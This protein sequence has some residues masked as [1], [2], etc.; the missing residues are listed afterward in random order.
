[1]MEIAITLPD[2]SVALQLALSLGHFLW[3]GVL[4]SLLAFVAG[5]VQRSRSQ[6]QYAVHVVALVL[7][8]ACFPLN[9]FW[10]TSSIKEN[11][12]PQAAADNA[13]GAAPVSHGQ[14]PFVPETH[15]EL[16]VSQDVPRRP[17]STVPGVEP[18]GRRSAQEVAPLTMATAPPSSAAPVTGIDNGQSDAIRV[19]APAGLL[20][21]VSTRL[22]G[23]APILVQ[24][25]LAGVTVLLLRLVLAASCGCA[26]RRNASPVADSI[27]DTTRHL[28]HRIGIQ[29]E[30]FVGC[31]ESIA[32]PVAIGLFRP[33]ILIPSAILTGLT[34]DQ[35]Q[36]V[37]LHELSH[38]R[39]R[40][41]L[42]VILQRLVE[43][44]LFFH[45]A[46]WI[47]SRQISI[48]REHCCDADVVKWGAG[49][50]E[51]AGCLLQIAEIQSARSSACAVALA[52]DGHRPSQLRS[53]VSRIL[54]MPDPEHGRITVSGILAVV[55][56]LGS[57]LWSLP[58]EAAVAETDA[59]ATAISRD[60]RGDDGTTDPSAPTPEMVSLRP[61]LRDASG[62]SVPLTTGD[63]ERASIGFAEAVS[64][65]IKWQDGALRLKPG[66]QLLAY[67]PA[68]KGEAMLVELTVPPGD[69][70][71]AISLRKR[72]AWSSRDQVALSVD[73][74]VYKREFGNSIRLTFQNS[75]E[76]DFTFLRPDIQLVTNRW[77]IIPTEA[78]QLDGFTLTRDRG[79]Y[80]HGFSWSNAV[81]HGIWI[82]RNHEVIT[83]SLPA[84]EPG[85]IWLG[86]QIGPVLLPNQLQ[87]ESPDVVIARD[88]RYRRDGKVSV[89]LDKPEFVLGENVLLH[90]SVTN[91]GEEPLRIDVGGDYRGSPRSLRF[92]VHAYDK[93]GRRLADP[94]PN[95]W[96]HGG[97][98]TQPEIQ[99]GENYTLS[100]PLLDYVQIDKP[101]TYRVR[102]FH[103]LGWN[104]SFGIPL[105]EN[106]VMP[107][108]DTVAPIVET[109]LRIREP[110]RED[111]QA[112]VA[113]AETPRPETAWGTRTP[114]FGEWSAMR[115]PVYLPFLLKAADDHDEVLETIALIPTQEATEALLRLAENGSHRAASLLPR[116]LP[117]PNFKKRK[118]WNDAWSLREQLVQKSWRSEFAERTRQIAW[119][120][121]ESTETE[122]YEERKMDWMLGGSILFHIGRSEDYARFVTAASPIVESLGTIAA[123]QQQYPSPLTVI[124]NFV[125]TGDQLIRRGARPDTAPQTAFESMMFVTA[126]QAASE[127]RPRSWQA[128][129]R[130]LL[131]HSMPR[132]RSTCVA[133]LPVP[134]E[135][136]FVDP[137]I[138]L[139]S[140]SSPLVAATALNSVGAAKDSRF[141][142]A[143][144][145]TSRESLDKWVQ[146]AARH[147]AA[148][149]T[150]V[151]E[152]KPN[153]VSEPANKPAS[154]AD[155]EQRAS[156]N[157][158]RVQIAVKR[159]E[160]DRAAL[161]FQRGFVTELTV[162]KLELDLAN[163]ATT[164]AAE[165]AARA[166]ALPHKED[167]RLSRRQRT[168][169]RLELI[170][171]QAV[172][173]RAAL[174]RAKLLQEK[175]LINRLEVEK[176]EFE[177]QTLL[178]RKVAEERL[179]EVESQDKA[180]GE[181]SRKETLE[182]K[183]TGES[184]AGVPLLF[185]LDV[186]SRTDRPLEYWCGGPGL[187]PNA[188]MFVAT[189]TDEKGESRTIVLHNGQNLEGSGVTRKVERKTSFPAA[190]PPLAP[191]RY[192]VTVS[193]GQTA[194]LAGAY[195]EQWPEMKSKPVAIEIRDEPSSVQRVNDALLDL[196]AKSPFA[197]HVTHVY[198]ISP[199]VDEWLR[200]LLND[201]PREAF[202]VVGY[203]ARCRRLPKGGDAIVLQAAKKHSTSRR[204]DKNLLR[205]ISMIGRNIGSESTIDAVMAIAT[206]DV[207]RYARAAAVSD[208]AE[209]PGPLAEKRLEQLA[210][211]PQSPVYWPAI[212][213]L[214]ARRNRLA[215]T[216]LLKALETA[217]G[218]RR[219]Q[220]RKLLQNFPDDPK[221][222]EAVRKRPNTGDSEQGASRSQNEG[223]SGEPPNAADNSADQ[224]SPKR[225]REQLLSSSPWSKPLNGLRIR[226][227]TD[228]QTF[229]AGDRLPLYVQL[230]NASDRP[231]PFGKLHRQID[232]RVTAN[233]GEWLGV[234][235]A[236]HDISPWEGLSGDFQPG[237]LIQWT[238]WLERA[239]LNRTVP[240]G[241][242]VT[243]KVSVPTQFTQPGQLP[244]T[245]YSEP[246]RIRFDAVPKS[247]LTSSDF[248]TGWS[249]E[250][251]IIYR[252]AGG[253]F[254]PSRALR[255]DGFGLCTAIRLPSRNPPQTPLLPL[256]RTMVPL[257]K[258][259][260]DRIA[261][262]LGS[263]DLRALSSP[264]RLAFP[265]EPTFLLTIAAGGRTLVG[266]FPDQVVRKTPAIKA[267]QTEMRSVMGI[268]KAT[269]EQA[270][271]SDDRSRQRQEKLMAD[272]DSFNLYLASYS[273]GET[274]RFSLRLQTQP[275]GPSHY[276][277]NRTHQLDRKQL[278]RL[279][280]GLARGGFLRQGKEGPLWKP[281]YREGYILFLAN[282]DQMYHEVLGL[283]R[284]R[285][286]VE[287]LTELQVVLD[288]DAARSLSLV[289]R[290]L[291]VPAEDLPDM[292]PVRQEPIPK[293]IRLRVFPT[294]PAKSRDAR[295]IIDETVSTAR[296][297]A[298]TA[299]GIRI[300]GRLSKA[301]TGRPRFTGT[302]RYNGGTNEFDAEIRFGQPLASYGGG[303]S[304]GILSYFVQLD[305]IT[306][307]P[308]Q[309]E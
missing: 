59:P 290:D 141:R 64:R 61:A 200:Q 198:G 224:V 269:S 182:V 74:K 285:E 124:A 194:V 130:R 179:R 110:S 166:E 297:F 191:G 288:G 119:R 184:I 171:A 220:I 258:E 66:K 162:R 24:I 287:R 80:E 208:L 277:Y 262:L 226:T 299:T 127:F 254:G 28:A 218:N 211:D 292:K 140:D 33:A 47:V 18:P 177:L 264:K 206:A 283:P 77:R 260:L 246:V 308:G 161:L 163:L 137:I 73:A 203:L 29:R 46:V 213:A 41:H 105:L 155:A 32:V 151:E 278:A 45:P 239:R 27:L 118:N 307:K 286:M 173:R 16:T 238:L 168:E 185:Q 222:I 250:N 174:D 157:R 6:W 99:P 275:T 94:F 298:L 256:G 188:S 15:D 305:L 245:E 248:S 230:Q 68:S 92:K 156:L 117:H 7:M 276:F 128:L 109:T 40:D 112:I 169:A 57:C 8:A 170:E 268:V 79:E 212:E 12:A 101:G 83:E 75:G 131:R 229:K 70:S 237:A 37:L 82:P 20:S 1:M 190:C 132:V 187:Y 186:T 266:S 232:V 160:L 52:S 252:E 263:M 214:A 261:A 90:Y 231:I 205:Y 235:R 244:T 139:F 26:L 144:L 165:E 201:D 67:R 158:L 71:K 273:P 164:L 193:C 98:S 199:I 25:W 301:V 106:N 9:L 86:L 265:D 108:V 76:E 243:V 14:R 62:K 60:P 91:Q 176:L 69:S 291:G 39:R 281:T 23:S 145:R 84:L 146:G 294:D 234:A 181:A 78:M 225:A 216:P 56:L 133:S 251:T 183:L 116:R 121:L 123:E 223:K 42:V 192:S 196:S 89:E 95:P 180:A 236:D 111:V 93:A 272:V 3:Q 55:I 107:T 88:E 136:Q 282:K 280:D 257:P 153:P 152:A 17:A 10:V 154:K 274:P 302:L 21:S 63:F 159:A 300:D 304:G 19:A 122:P 31:C 35:V 115:H 11:A 189:I 147:A 13:I 38:F 209:I 120:L 167:S 134:I 36:L 172:A 85:T 72:S 295:P 103:D 227:A 138:E 289:L 49:P 44:L 54:G 204:P 247:T 233:N 126:L 197:R 293:E 51:Y 143:A 2:S 22:A 217:D 279:M 125:S 129:A 30:I 284:N 221:A 309:P 50:V 228:R 306:S 195:S 249:T 5:C 255:I 303:F 175:G 178:A 100:V 202:K 210:N 148:N 96:C 113:E 114:P 219:V 149:C 240:P 53:R 48:Q 296:P 271:E 267:L 215:L 4:I 34:P 241:T 150:P 270:S 102:V 253:L 259:C 43:T 97:L 104:Q 242:T 87:V 65:P 207:D 81:R 142:E 58:R 135:P